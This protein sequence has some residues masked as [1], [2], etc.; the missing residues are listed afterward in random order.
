MKPTTLKDTVHS[1]KEK[2]ERIATELK[3]RDI[4]IKNNIR[5]FTMLEFVEEF[6][7]IILM[8]KCDGIDFMIIHTDKDTIPEVHFFM[9]NQPAS[10]DHIYPYVIWFKDKNQYSL[11]PEQGLCKWIGQKEEEDFLIDIHNHF[12]GKQTL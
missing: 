4:Y 6:K 8:L 11:N 2:R 12:F 10:R 7:D 3:L 5:K 9:P 1:I